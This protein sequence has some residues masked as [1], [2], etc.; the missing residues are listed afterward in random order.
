MSITAYQTCP[1]CLASTY[2]SGNLSCKLPK[3][4]NVYIRKSISYLNQLLNNNNN[5][6]K[7]ILLVSF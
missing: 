2:K 7:Y 5:N 3:N 1:K 4:D 6:N